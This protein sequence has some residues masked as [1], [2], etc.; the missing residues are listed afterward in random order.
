MYDNLIADYGDVTIKAPEHFVSDASNY[1]QKQLD[2]HKQIL[3]LLSGGSSITQAVAVRNKL[4]V[5]PGKLIAGLI[6]E[7]YG[8]RNHADSNWQQL[9]QSGWDNVN[10]EELRVEPKERAT[11]TEAAAIYEKTLKKTIATVDICVGFFG[12]G[13]DGHTAGML[14]S[15]PAVSST[16]YVVG[17]DAGEFQRITITPAVMSHFS[18]AFI[19]SV[20][21][22][23]HAAI[24]NFLQNGSIEEVP[25]RALKLAKNVTLYTD[26]KKGD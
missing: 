26:Y 20:S 9:Y 12:I 10:L 3:L 7:R 14:P 15:S 24:T 18:R 6:D 23:K 1:L 8:P 19:Y 22:S 2:A 25:A 16:N 13:A 17:Y 21:Q 4:N 5:P 11:L